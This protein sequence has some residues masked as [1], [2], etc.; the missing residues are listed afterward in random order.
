MQM[1]LNPDTK[2]YIPKI[3]A[4]VLIAT[5]LLIAMNVRYYQKYADFVSVDAMITDVQRHIT[6]SPSSGS[7]TS[8]TTH[9]TYQYN[10][11]S[12]SNASKTYT[13]T[14]SEFFRFGKEKGKKV[15]VKINPES[16]D[17]IENT[18]GRNACRMLTAFCFAIDAFL[19]MAIRQIKQEKE[20]GN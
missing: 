10:Y 19:W 2:K 13:T 14:R 11:G 9:V 20:N 15:V 6:S 5:T 17:E 1:T 7:K 12:S 4:A 18:Y 3:F 16:P 8:Y